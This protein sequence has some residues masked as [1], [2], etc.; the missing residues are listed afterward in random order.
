[1]TPELESKASV[2]HSLVLQRW[3][4]V[5]L[6]NQAT[7]R[8]RQFLCAIFPEGKTAYFRQ[9]LKVIPC[10]PTPKDILESTNLCKVEGLRQ[11]LQ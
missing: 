5:K 4:F 8:L 1:M 10:Y 9:F 11:K 6:A 2:L 3:Q 7:N